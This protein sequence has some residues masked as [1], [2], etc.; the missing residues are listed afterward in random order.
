M[1]GWSAA[2]NLIIANSGLRRPS[3]GVNLLGATW[4]MGSALGPQVVDRVLSH[5][6]LALGYYG[7][8]VLTGLLLPLFWSTPLRLGDHH[9]GEPHNTRTW[10]QY[11]PYALIFIVYVGA[12]TGF[13]AWVFTQLTVAGSAST[14]QGALAASL[15]WAGLTCGRMAAAVVLRH[16]GERRLLFVCALIVAGGALALMASPHATTAAL[17]ISF[18]I[19]LACGPIFPTTYGLIFRSLP[20]TSSTTLGTLQAVG[21]C[22]GVLLPPI[23]GY[24]GGGKDGG[25]IVVAGLAVL[26]ASLVVWVARRRQTA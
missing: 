1:G 6:S 19:G 10:Q 5:G 17:G 3:V 20:R 15:F 11:L 23:Q 22:G 4:G 16:I 24:V 14:A 12:E 25:M 18:A 21:I 8:A 7:T 9:A 26:I 2:P 13:G